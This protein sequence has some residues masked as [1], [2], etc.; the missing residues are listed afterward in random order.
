M[1]SI[2][3]ITLLTESR[4]LHPREPNEY[5]R[6]ILTEDA[7]M[8]GALE[9]L[10]LRVDRADWADPAADWSAT[11]AA[12]FRTTWN[13][14]ERFA[15][16]TRWLDSA[17][18]QTRLINPP[19]LVRWNMDKHY[20]ADLER[21]GIAVPPTRFVERGE[22]VTLAE[23]HRETGWS[24]TVL[25]PAVS[26]GGRHT[27]R[28]R[29]ENAGELEETFRSLLKDEAMMLQPF[30]PG[31]ETEGEV[32]LVVIAGRYSHAVLKRAKP[33]EFRVQDDFGGTVHHYAP[34]AE[35]IAF[36]ERVMSVCT[37]LPLYGRVD[38]I[39]DGGRSVVSELELIEPELWFRFHPPAA[40][41]LAEAVR[42]DYF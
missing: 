6:N 20:L 12:L 10:G 29:P 41:R 15:E 40:D 33:G 39:R 11:S 19:E 4:Y 14:F 38:I 27:Y 32:T 23:L 26:G 42:R 13:Y 25:K 3:D 1:A 37:P 16:F 22:R 24:E 9:R 35:E 31:I 28:L 21:R 18:A 8:R 36:A 7:L 17:S 2:I 34:S 5:V 30:F